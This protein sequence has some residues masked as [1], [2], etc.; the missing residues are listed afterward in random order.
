MPDTHEETDTV[1]IGK[2]GKTWRRSSRSMTNG[3]CVEV[4][5]LA[6]GVVGVRDSKKEQG[7]FLRFPSAPWI[8]FLRGVRSGEFG[9]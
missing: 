1:S 5:G 7:N 8:A 9:D 6:P 3:N 2:S 4:T